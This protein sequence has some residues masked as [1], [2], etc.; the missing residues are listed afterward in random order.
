MQKTCNFTKIYSTAK[1]V[2]PLHMCVLQKYSNSDKNF[3]LRDFQNISKCIKYIIK[4]ITGSKELLFWRG[5]DENWMIHFQFCMPDD[6]KNFLQTGFWLHIFQTVFLLHHPRPFSGRSYSSFSCYH[7]SSGLT[8]LCHN[9]GDS[10]QWM[11]R[12]GLEVIS[13]PNQLAE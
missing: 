3:L 6:W 13:T 10:K 7:A 4:Y 11:V 12:V 2:V 8:L 9:V 1:F 5:T